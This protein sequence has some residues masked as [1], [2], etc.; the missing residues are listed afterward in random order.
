MLTYNEYKKWS[1][2]CNMTVYKRLETIFKSEPLKDKRANRIYLSETIVPDYITP[3]E[4]TSFLEGKG[5]KII[6][7][8][9]GT[10]LPPTGL[11]PRKKKQPIK[12]GKA[13]TKLGRE[14]LVKV[15]SANK[16]LYSLD[17][18]LM[19]VISRHP[20]DLVG[21]STRRRWTSCHD[22]YDK[23]YSGGYLY[24]LQKYSLEPGGIIAYLIR[25]DDKNIND[26]IS[27]IFVS[28]SGPYANINSM[29]GITSIPFQTIVRN[30]VTKVNLFNYSH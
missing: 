3:V 8:L 15:Y 4:I 24:Q 20:Y 2:A 23:K 9:K 12:I 10:C 26:P 17:D 7:H 21:M 19:V 11:D 6:S 14:D 27:R 5:Y 16:S 18:N 30:W 28:L 25:K 29:Y 13:L 1:S 22:L